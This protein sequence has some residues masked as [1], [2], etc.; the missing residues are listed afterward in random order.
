[1]CHLSSKQLLLTSVLKYVDGV[2]KWT[3]DITLQLLRPYE[4][5]T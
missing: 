5:D 2:I 4:I 1:M 3:L